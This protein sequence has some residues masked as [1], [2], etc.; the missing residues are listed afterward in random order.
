MLADTLSNREWN[1]AMHIRSATIARAWRDRAT[2][3]PE[4]PHE[5][6]Q[7][8]L[9]FAKSEARA[10]RSYLQMYRNSVFLGK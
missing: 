1:L 4:T 6:R 10:A 8:R 2:E 9:T 3:N 5:T 7:F